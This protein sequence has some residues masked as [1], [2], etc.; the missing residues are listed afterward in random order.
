MTTTQDEDHDV[1][2]KNDYIVVDS[3]Q[4]V[5]DRPVVRSVVCPYMKNS[6]L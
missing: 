4:Q 5:R 2:A 1:N 3:G 6:L